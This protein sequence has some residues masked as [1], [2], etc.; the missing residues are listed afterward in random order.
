MARKTKYILPGNFTTIPLESGISGLDLDKEVR[1]ILNE[2]GY[3]CDP[4][5][6]GCEQPSICDLIADCP[7]GG[8]GSTFISLT[9]TPGSYSTGGEI[10]V[11]NPGGTALIF[12][13]ID[14][15]LQGADVDVFL[16]GATTLKENYLDLDDTPGAYPG[17]G[18]VAIVNG[19]NDGMSFDTLD[20][21]L[22]GATI[23][24]T[25]DN[26]LTKTLNNIQLGGDLIKNTAINPDTFEYEVG[27]AG[28]LG[29]FGYTQSGP[30]RGHPTPFWHGESTDGDG[31]VDMEI[32]LFSTTIA[33]WLVTAIDTGLT[34][35]SELLVS[36]D[37]TVN[38]RVENTTSGNTS[39]LLVIDSNATLRCESPSGTMDIEARDTYINL[40]VAATD[41]D[42]AAIRI[43][44]AADGGDPGIEIV[45]KK[46]DTS[47]A[48]VGKALVL[49]NTDGLVEF[50]DYVEEEVAT[51][52]GTKSV[53]DLPGTINANV[54][55]GQVNRS[56]LT[57]TPLS[58]GTTLFQLA[59]IQGAAN[60]NGDGVPVWYSIKA[61]GSSIGQTGTARA[62][63]QGSQT[64]G[65]DLVI[66]ELYLNGSNILEVAVTN[67]VGHTLELVLV[68]E[69]VQ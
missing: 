18:Q 45:T 66:S 11:I 2:C 28:S 23:P 29:K 14:T 36:T 25:A 12:E 40:N 39:Q 60:N 41:T 63:Y 64:T 15:I 49:Q 62:S 17:A 56:I 50:D 4:C 38:A 34:E 5:G 58:T 59:G 43:E 6:D 20:N 8:G 65:D 46:V 27:G 42:V 48:T 26:G 67:N 57:S 35:T 68:I 61:T 33:R 69:Y 24:I 51:G 37:G 1:A 3:P 32:D 54:G 21:L 53:I 16:T 19:T 9:D 31:T 55:T 30:Q 52:A 10:P 7:G 13:D 47:T 22:S 44:V